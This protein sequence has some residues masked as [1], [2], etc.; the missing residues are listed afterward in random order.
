MVMQHPMMP[1]AAAMVMQHPMPAPKSPTVLSLSLSLSGKL[2]AATNFEKIVIRSEIGGYLIGEQLMECKA[3][4][5]LEVKTLCDQA[6]AILV[7][8]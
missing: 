8:E 2:V 3:L 5:E 4:T 7:E 1:P 6:R